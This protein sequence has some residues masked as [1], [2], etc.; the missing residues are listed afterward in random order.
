[1]DIFQIMRQTVLV[2]CSREVEG[3]IQDDR[4]ATHGSRML[5]FRNIE[6]LVDLQVHHRCIFSFN[7][8]FQSLCCVSDAVRCRMIR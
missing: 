1:M 5:V 8:F 7:I 4:Y 3:K 2:D 6:C